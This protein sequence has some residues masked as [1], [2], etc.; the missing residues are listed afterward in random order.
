[1]LDYSSFQ[2]DFDEIIRNAAELY[3]DTNI[4]STPLLKDWAK[5]KQNI[6]DGLLDGQLS[7]NLGYVEIQMSDDGKHAV[8]ESLISRLNLFPVVRQY[9][10]DFLR[11]NEDSFWLNTVT[12]PTG[13][14]MQV[15]MKITRALKFLIEDKNVLDSVQTEISMVLQQNKMSGDLIVSIHPLDFLSSSENQHNWRSCHALDGEY[16]AGN[17]S[18]MVDKNTMICYIKSK[19]DVELNYFPCLWNNKKWRM[20]LE[21]NESLNFLISGR[22][23]P[24]NLGDNVLT[25]I[26]KGLFGENALDFD[27]SKWSKNYIEEVPGD[28][29]ETIH[30]RGRYIPVRRYLYR[31]NKV[32]ED[33]EG[34]L[35][36]ND[37]KL[38][39]Y[40][41]PYYSFLQNARTIPKVTVGGAATCPCCGV[42]KITDSDTLVCDACNP[43]DY[44]DC[45]WC[46]RRFRE[47]DLEWICS[48]DWEGYVCPECLENSFSVCDNCG[49]IY[50][51]EE[52]HE[53]NGRAYCDRCYP[54]E[55]D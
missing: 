51:A 9:V 23:Y 29:D 43:G 10:I 47:R 40:Y 26:S 21:V 5:A 41:T 22:Q 38:S 2:A 27:W 36:Y 18:Y 25:E 11:N 35:N 33:G 39:S 1:M 12:V 45:D 42:N 13:D 53:Y 31:Y 3:K 8:F 17:L 52:L 6:S 48:H 54:G 28:N 14:K 50:P 49:E 19:D 55:D 24:F 30:L 34:A 7:K 32:V 4:N 16:R 20:L 44:F 46:G 37:L 15:G